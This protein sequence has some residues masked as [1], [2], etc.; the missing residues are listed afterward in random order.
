M[1]AAESSHGEPA[2]ADGTV[3]VE[4][5]SGVLGAAGDITAGRWPSP[6]SHLVPM[7]KADQGSDEPGRLIGVLGPI[8]RAVR[9][10]RRGAGVRD[11]CCHHAGWS[12]GLSPGRAKLRR[13]SC[14]QMASSARI[15]VSRSSPKRSGVD[16][17]AIPIRYMPDRSCGANSWTIVRSWRRMRFRSTALPTLRPMAYA[18]RGGSAGL[19]PTKDT[20]TSPLRARIGRWED[21][22]PLGGWKSRK[23]DLPRTRQI[24]P[25]A[26]CDP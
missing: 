17:G 26:A 14:A 22:V 10:G 11:R 7:D 6:A 1:A 24:R 16:G 21:G 2:S 19:P 18:T 9:R 12:T 8:G 3:S 4:G 13:V 5:D 23:A 25:T 15:T 20:V